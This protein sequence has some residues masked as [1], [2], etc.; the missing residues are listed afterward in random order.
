MSLWAF[1]TSFSSA[2]LLAPFSPESLCTALKLQSDSVRVH[3][4]IL[5]ASV[6]ARTV[7]PFTRSRGSLH[8]RHDNAAP[9][10]HLRARLPSTYAHSLRRRVAN[11]TNW[12]VLLTELHTHLLRTLL[13]NAELLR[14]KL[15][16]PAK[17][18][19]GLLLQQVPTAA[20]VTSVSWPEVLR[21]VCWL[22]LDETKDVCPLLRS[23]LE[24]LQRKDYCELDMAR[25]ASRLSCMLGG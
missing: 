25:A 20:S 4:S 3:T 24:A 5:R 13:R 11:E 6:R 1:A 9:T 8:R 22:L 23:A 18:D 10:H 2:L 12:Q 16:F 19:I 17:L 7:R 14:D 15:Q 21:S